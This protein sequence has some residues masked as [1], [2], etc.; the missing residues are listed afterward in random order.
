MAVWIIFNKAYPLKTI[1]Q[2]AAKRGLYI[3]NG[4]LFDTPENSYNAMRFGFASLNLT[5]ITEAVHILA[6]CI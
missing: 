6:Q 5:E 1:A 2:K 4:N 3:N